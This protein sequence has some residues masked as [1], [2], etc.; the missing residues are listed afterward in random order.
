MQKISHLLRF[1]C[2][3]Y[4]ITNFQNGKRYVGSSNNIYNRLHEHVH[5][6]NKNKAHNN[7]LQS[8]WNKYGQDSFGYAILQYCSEEDRFVMEQHY[9]DALHPEYNLTE[10]VVAN[11][12]HSPSEES[13]KKISDTLKRKYA[14][15]EIETYKQ[16]HAWKAC[17]IYDVTTFS[18]VKSFKNLAD[19]SKYISR[20]TGSNSPISHGAQMGHIINNKY[21]IILKSTLKNISSVKD[22]ITENFLKC[23]SSRGKYL[24]VEN[25]QNERFYFRYISDC[26]RFTGIS[27]SMILKHPDATKENPYKPEKVEY[28]IYYSN[29]YL[30]YNNKAV[31]QRNLLNHYRAISENA[32]DGNSEINLII[33]Y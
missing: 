23:V 16:D 4:C 20:L 33:I 26:Y 25:Y 22:F 24:I 27:S 21:C 11:L 9:I 3:I 15:G 31:Q 8:A 32:C 7:H 17:S 28:I 12:G 29:E 1:K 5:N 2:G 10:Q 6:L 13:K 19:A 30:G 18:E 14:S